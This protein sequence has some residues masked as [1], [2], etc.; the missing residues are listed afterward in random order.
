MGQLIRVSKRHLGMAVVLVIML[1]ITGCSSEVRVKTL[2]ND[3]DMGS[4][5]IAT[6]YYEIGEVAELKAVANR[7]YQF[8]HWS[9][10]V[11][12]EYIYDNPLSITVN[13]YLEVVA[14]FEVFGG[15]G[16]FTID[17]IADTFILGD[18]RS[19]DNYGERA[20]LEI[21]L[22]ALDSENNSH[23][24]AFFAFDIG[25]WKVVQSATL[26]LYVE[27]AD[28]PDALDLRTM[29]VYDV[30][31]QGDWA[32]N[33]LTWNNTP[34]ELMT[35]GTLVNQFDVSGF[36]VA[37]ENGKWYE[38]DVT[39][40]VKN[41]TSEGTSEISLRVES[42]TPHYVLQ[43]YFTSREGAASNRPVL[44]IDGTI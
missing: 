6:S 43:A 16:V 12:E 5:E 7:G 36:D 18:W 41:H 15:S 19:G 38:V 32:E 2:V 34:D 40:L 25:Q 20:S 35:G 10:D 11:P 37:A 33:D 22:D 14:N 44:V 3:R 26:K 21:K 39:E 31:N 13:D 17:A 1:L 29:A 4:V 27:Q 8:G 23:R 24:K 30:T 9:G 28:S 42:L